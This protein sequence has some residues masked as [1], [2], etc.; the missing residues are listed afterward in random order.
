[1]SIESDTSSLGM[2][3]T[4]SQFAKRDQEGSSKVC[5]DLFLF[6]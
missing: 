5:V 6:V 2:K 1:V 4:V 3:D